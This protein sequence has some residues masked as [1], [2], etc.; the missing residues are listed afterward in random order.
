MDE[1]EV[2]FRVSAKGSVHKRWRL[3]LSYGAEKW[4]L[5]AQ[6]QPAGH[7]KGIGVPTDGE[8]PC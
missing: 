2:T 8:V 1:Y 7:D 6:Q 4:A 5:Q 3:S